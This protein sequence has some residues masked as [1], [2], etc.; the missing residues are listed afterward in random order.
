MRLVRK[1]VAISILIV[2]L[3]GKSEFFQLL[4]I[5]TLIEH[6]LEHSSQDPEMNLFK[7]IAIHYA[8]HLT[9]DEDYDKDMK[10]PFKS[11]VS[12]ISSDFLELQ[13]T[14]ISIAAAPNKTNFFVFIF[15][16]PRV[17]ELFF[18]HLQKHFSLIHVSA[19]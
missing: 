13:P 8:H 6:Y 16:P 10:L 1:F 9:I 12:L 3:L 7:F 19:T 18:L 14:P 4:R 17:Y 2:F 15:T 11:N 5:S